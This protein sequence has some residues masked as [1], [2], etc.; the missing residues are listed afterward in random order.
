MSESLRRL[1]MRLPGFRPERGSW[2]VCSTV[3]EPVEILFAFVSH[4][5]EAGAQEVHLFIDDPEQ[6]GLETLSA[7]NGV[8]LTICDAAHWK[9]LTGQR[10]EGQVMRQLRNANL[11]YKQS[12]TEWFF[13]CDADEFF[14]SEKPVSELLDAV[15]A[16]V[17]HCRT[18]MAERAF[19]AEQPQHEL[20]DG[21][22]RV[23]LV[24]GDAVLQQVYGDLAPMTTRGLSGHVA[25][26]SFVRTGRHD[27]R[28]RIHFPVPMDGT[29]EERLRAAKQLTAGPELEGGRLVHYDGITLLHWRLKLLRYYLS[30]A[31]KLKAGDTKVFARRTPARSRQLNAIYEAQGDPERLA[32]LVPLVY[33]NARMLAQLEQ[34][35]GLWDM[36]VD[37]AQAARRIVSPDLGFRANEFD[38]QLRA[39]HGDLISQFR[40]EG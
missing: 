19:R 7:L 32:Q 9:A 22:L 6:S 5:L 16:D 3:A 10:P 14:V 4:Y 24:R 11:A 36:A 15:P 29:E 17:I 38:A 34:A 27:Q 2:S 30:Y 13:F 21:V 28:I 20:F 37:P 12:R 23:P 26:K 35:G 18:A 31:P 8:R 1:R 33:L 39:R 40:L 25:G